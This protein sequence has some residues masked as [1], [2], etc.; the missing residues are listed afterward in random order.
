MIL[1]LIQPGDRP[2]GDE[3]AVGHYVDVGDPVDASS[4]SDSPFVVFVTAR[5]PDGTTCLIEESDDLSS[6]S[7]MAGVSFDPS[8]FDPPIQLEHGT[9]TKRYVRATVEYDIV[10]SA[11]R[12]GI[13]VVIGDI[14]AESFSPSELYAGRLQQGEEAV[15]VVQ[16]HDAA[17]TPDDPDDSPSIQIY[18]DGA[19]PE[20]ISSLPMPSSERR[21][22]DGVFRIPIF[23]DTLYSTTGRYLVVV[24]W[25]DGDGVAR[26]QT[27]SF[28]L[29]PGGNADGAVIAMCNLNRRDAT[30][31]MTQCDSGRL[32]RKR[33]PR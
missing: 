29:L 1:N 15:V 4:L 22:E 19:T 10:D 24:K 6:W 12:W 16:C 17:G 30:Y 23:L 14:E 9:R 26:V 13:S 28:H 7:A 11:D 25:L 21:V 8:E 33:N 27:G 5:I 2:Y 18:L 31:L 32:I 3:P 20:L